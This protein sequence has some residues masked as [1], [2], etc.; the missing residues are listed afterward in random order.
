[1]IFFIIW[2]FLQQI[3]QIEPKNRVHVKKSE[4]AAD[5]NIPSHFKP[6][7]YQMGT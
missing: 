7:Q 6:N 2:K 1:M 3:K 4:V 5:I